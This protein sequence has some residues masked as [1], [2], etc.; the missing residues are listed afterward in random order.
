MGIY[1][2]VLIYKKNNLRDYCFKLNSRIKI[3]LI[4]FGYLVLKNFLYFNL[5][6]E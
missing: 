6:F 5:D 1:K 2:K 4:I 3:V